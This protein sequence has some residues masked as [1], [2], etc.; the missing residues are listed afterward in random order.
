MMFDFKIASILLLYFVGHF[1]P[2]TG[3]DQAIWSEFSC[4][5]SQFEGIERNNLRQLLI[6]DRKLYFLFEVGGYRS[7]AVL[8]LLANSC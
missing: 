2:T 3:Y 4:K 8:G 5:E 7:I 6:L 1:H